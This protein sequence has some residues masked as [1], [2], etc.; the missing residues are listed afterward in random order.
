MASFAALC[1]LMLTTV[2]AFAASVTINDQAGV[3]NK[4][5]VQ[6]EGSSLPYPLKVYTVSNFNGNSS[7]FS[8]QAK[9]HVSNSTDIVIAIDTANKHLAIQAGSGVSLSSSQAQ[10]AV[11]AFKQ[12]YGN[13][14]YT[15]GTVSAIRSLRSSLGASA[16]RGNGRG[17]VP[18][19]SQPA[20]NS[21]GF[22]TICCVGL[23]VLLGLA[24]FGIF[25]GRRNQ[26]VGVGA[27]GGLFGNRMGMGGVF[28]NRMNQQQPYNPNY[29]G[30][31]GYPPNNYGGYP[32]NYPNQGQGMNPL[33]AGGLGAAAGGLLGYE[34]GKNAGER[35]NNQNEGNFGGGDLGNNNGGDFGGGASGD[36]GG[37]GGDF[38]GGGS[39]DF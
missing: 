10:D 19:P 9:S 11:S 29:P 8:Q 17:N 31:G 30:P 5:Q 15:G 38:G 2:S 26:G 27:G 34:L 32:P 39:G 28:G 23:L 4:G 18:V 36:F 35:E 13:G 6:S 14:D 1:L 7:A 24:A 20:G 16:S 12:S 3:L 22:G 21:I 37:G 25:R 33:A